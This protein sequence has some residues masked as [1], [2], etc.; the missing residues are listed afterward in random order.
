MTPDYSKLPQELVDKLSK[1]EQ[2]SPVQKQLTI[3]ND[4][5]DML[6]DLLRT[7]DSETKSG[8][9]TT[10]EM[11]ALL[12]DMRDSLAAL[13]DR[14]DPETP[15]FAAPV[16]KAV[17]QLETAIKQLEV[18]P[19][20]KPT[21]KVDSP[22]VTVTAPKLDL[23]G[24]EQLLK[25]DIPKAFAQAIAAI[26]EPP[27]P[28]NREQLGMLQGILEQLSS[29]DTATRMKPSFPKVME[30][31]GTVDTTSPNYATRIDDT[32]TSITYV[33]KAALG[34]HPTDPVWQIQKIDATNGTVISWAAGSAN[35]NQ[36]WDDRTS[37]TYL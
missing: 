26:P 18:K 15:D 30:V 19:E 12:V 35:F 17:A 10:K 14:Q 31:T 16:V 4:L 27:V 28:D 3:L 23:K 33:G 37:L 2:N 22:S 25:T 1:W 24:I 6:Q 29:I 36:V 34:S 8:H 32:V 5:A 11:G 21:V 7:V 9:Q 20:F 13:K